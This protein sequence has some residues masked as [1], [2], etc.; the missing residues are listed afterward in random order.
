MATAAETRSADN[1][2]VTALREEA[3]DRL[4]SAAQFFDPFKFVTYTETMGRHIGPM[5]ART[6]KENDDE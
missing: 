4:R 6:E 1:A 2:G 5:P 3:A